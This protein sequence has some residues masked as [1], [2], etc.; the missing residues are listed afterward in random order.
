MP[1]VNWFSYVF[2]FCLSCSRGV[3]DGALFVYYSIM[4]L[5]CVISSCRLVAD[6][7]QV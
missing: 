2:M 7:H 6:F 5:H 1:C 4:S 3:F